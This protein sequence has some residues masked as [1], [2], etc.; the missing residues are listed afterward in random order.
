M[1]LIETLT[2]QID[3]SY[4]TESESGL[5]YTFKIPRKRLQEKEESRDKLYRSV[6]F[7]RKIMSLTS[8]ILEEGVNSKTYDLILE[9][10][11]ET[12][13]GVEKGSITKLM[14]DNR[15][16]FVAVRGFSL[17]KLRKV[18]FSKH[19]NLLKPG[20]NKAKV[21]S[22]IELIQREEAHFNEDKIDYL[23]DYGEINDIKSS[24]IVPITYN[25][26]I[27][28][29]LN[30]NCLTSDYVFDDD[31]LSMASAFAAQIGLVLEHFEKD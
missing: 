26:Y 6:L 2:H 19:E 5:A 17:R 18:S 25:K 28:A 23:N 29:M 31:D 27:G 22:N 7:N 8:K 21:V 3:G 9:Y 14:S 10:A 30:L 24:I 15:Y 11:I 13:K 4:V 1:I 20:E 16:H 12:I